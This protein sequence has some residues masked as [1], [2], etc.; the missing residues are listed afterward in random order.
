MGWPRP[1]V[2]HLYRCRRGRVCPR[3]G[4]TDHS[5]YTRRAGHNPV[6]ESDRDWQGRWRPCRLGR[7]AR[8]Y[9]YQP[10]PRRAAASE[11]PKVYLALEMPGRPIPAA[12]KSVPPRLR[13]LIALL[14][15]AS[16]IPRASR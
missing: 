8:G 3:V 5:L 7:L 12:L 11:V 13:V 9:L 6:D 2:R 16:L 10:E 1:P 15:I 14:W 4:W